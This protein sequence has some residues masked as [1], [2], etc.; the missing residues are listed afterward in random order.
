MSYFLEYIKHQ[1]SKSFGINIEEKNQSVD[2]ILA[3]SCYY[4][5][6]TYFTK[7]SNKEI[8]KICGGKDRVTVL[9]SL[10]NF[11][12]DCKI[13]P[14]LK[15]KFEELKN[16]IGAFVFEVKG[17]ETEIESSIKNIEK[18]IEKLKIIQKNNSKYNE[19]KKG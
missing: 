7:H 1:T 5:L 9:N 14:V 16:K 4:Q 10:E 15:Q 3:R 19:P 2:Y 13:H 11:K 8:G 18:S 17:S 6:S 12:V